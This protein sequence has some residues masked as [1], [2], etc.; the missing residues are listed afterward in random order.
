MIDSLDGIRRSKSIKPGLLV[1]RPLLIIVKLS[2]GDVRVK[3][4]PH[5]RVKRDLGQSLHRGRQSSVDRR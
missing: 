5:I 4:G 1:V 2:I 3:G